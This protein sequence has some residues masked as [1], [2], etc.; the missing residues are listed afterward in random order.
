M[1]SGCVSAG[2]GLFVMTNE[3]DK[4][5]YPRIGLGVALVDVAGNQ[6][7]I[8]VPVVVPVNSGSTY[9]LIGISLII[10]QSFQTGMMK[11]V[12]AYCAFILSATGILAPWKGAG[13]LQLR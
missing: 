5:L 13:W 1:G 9:N 8:D 10:R 7:F 11:F 12:S 6:I 3:V 4:M 2:N